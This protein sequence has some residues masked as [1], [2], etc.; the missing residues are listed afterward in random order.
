MKKISKI[1]LLFLVCISCL[2]CQREDELRGTGVK[3]IKNNIE[4][5]FTPVEDQGKVLLSEKQGQ[6]S[7]S[8]Y[9]YN[10]NVEVK[11][12]EEI[13]PLEEAIKEGEISMDKVLEKA[14]GD[15]KEESMGDYIYADGG[16]I[17]Y[18]YEDYTLI[19]LNIMDGG[20]KDLYICPKNTKLT[21]IDGL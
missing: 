2:A 20:S 17:E 10:G 4:I 21:E 7:Y 1:V 9:S 11:I 15:F 14:E 6:E 19:K 8:V 3:E 5:K 16:S 18:P 13:Y 12:G